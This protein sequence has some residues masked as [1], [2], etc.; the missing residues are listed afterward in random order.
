MIRFGRV[1]DLRLI[2][3]AEL[4]RPRID[5]VVQT[6]GAAARYCRFTSVSYYRAVEM[7]ANAREDQF[8]NQV[9]AGV[10]E[11]ERVLIEKGLTP[12]EARECLLSV[13]SEE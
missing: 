3:S 2:P 13:C 6:S 9:A 11:A 7:A 5:V 12:K 4:G 10:V 1:T 8:E